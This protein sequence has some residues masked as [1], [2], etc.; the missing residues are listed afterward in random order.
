[1]NKSTVYNYVNKIRENSNQ[2]KCLRGRVAI[3]I[4]KSLAYRDLSA[5]IPT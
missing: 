5:F 1:M 4:H 3:G 2:N